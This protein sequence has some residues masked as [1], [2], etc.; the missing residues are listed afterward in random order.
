M[1]T[2]V[3]IRRELAYHDK[4]ISKI[5]SRIK[6]TQEKW[7]LNDYSPS[8][9][10]WMKDDILQKIRMI[11]VSFYL[12]KK[13]D[14]QSMCNLAFEKLCSK[15]NNQIQQLLDNNV[16]IISE[17]D[18]DT[19]KRRVY[20]WERLLHEHRNN[21]TKLEELLSPKDVTVK[22]PDTTWDS[23]DDDDDNTDSDSE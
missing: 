13:F 16:K 14:P 21:K 22:L 6:E 10:Q 7:L 12:L 23:D 2:D 1:A 5:T 8:E 20:N 17:G 19:M 4:Q 11:L 15:I 9:K 3:R 18:R